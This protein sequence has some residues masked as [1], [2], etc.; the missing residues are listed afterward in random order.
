MKVGFFTFLLIRAALKRNYKNARKA[1]KTVWMYLVF[2]QI[3][4]KNTFF[5]SI[6]NLY[7]ILIQKVCS[8][9][10][11]NNNHFQSHCMTKLSKTTAFPVIAQITTQL[12]ASKKSYLCFFK[13]HCN[14]KIFKFS[15]NFPLQMLNFLFL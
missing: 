11:Y 3:K 4:K 5:A 13:I 10:F 7:C 14:I 8:C 6:P 9:W 2:W 1:L 15:N 12:G